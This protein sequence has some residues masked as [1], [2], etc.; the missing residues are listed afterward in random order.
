MADE[1]RAALHDCLHRGPAFDPPPTVDLAVVAFTP[2]GSVVWANVLVQRGHAAGVVAQIP[3]DGGS[4]SD[5]QFLKD[6]TDDQRRSIAW[7]PGRNWESLLP[8]PV[9]AGPGP[10]RTIAPYPASLLKLMVAVG[11]GCLI[12]EG[13]CAWDSVWAYPAASAQPRRTVLHW[14]EAMITVSDNEATSAL[15]AL[16]HHHGELDTSPRHRLHRRFEALG[17]STLQLH[18]TRP[19]GGWLNRDGA[20]VGHLHMTA[21]DTVRLLWRLLED[22]GWAPVSPTWSA[23]AARQALLRAPTAQQVWALL[24]AQQL[25]EVLSS[26]RHVG[27]P[28]WQPGIAARFAHKTGTTE[29]Y[30][31]DAGW[32]RSETPGGRNY[33]IA[34]LSTLGSR[35]A[36]APGLAAPWVIPALGA[37]IDAWLARH[38]AHQPATGTHS[39]GL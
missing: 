28:G 4:L 2:H 23:T 36:A 3:D 18:N 37:R 17:L 31:S 14:T 24:D 29:N 27:Q 32:A 21:W 25:N 20:G 5:V 12:D 22:A 7:Q 8:L 1:L 6:P 34:L 38:E 9:L 10:Y 35:H 39:P 19:D 33:L 26:G 13:A 11:V 30:L 16:L 15:I